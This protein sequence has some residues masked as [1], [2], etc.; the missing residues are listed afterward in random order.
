MSDTIIAAG[1]APEASEL[2]PIVAD[3]LAPVSPSAPDSARHSAEGPI[4][5][6]PD[7]PEKADRIEHI[8]RTLRDPACAR[9]V[10]GDAG[11][12]LLAALQNVALWRDDGS[13]PRSLVVASASPGEGRTTI[14]TAMA[15]LL[16]AVEPQLRVLLVDADPFSDAMARRLYSE[17]RGEGL[18]DYLDDGAPAVG[19]LPRRYMFDNLHVVCAKAEDDRPSPGRVVASRL[20]AFRAAT[21]AEYDLVIYDGPAH[22]A[23]G[24][25]VTLARVVGAV[26]LVVRYR[27]PLREQI[28]RLISE[29]DLHHVD[30]VG[31]V[32]NRRRLPI[33]GWLYGR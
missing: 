11:R 28:Q 24:E 8:V 33:P 20:A 1:A 32:F 21:E 14:A 29:L 18:F 12:R 13:A 27:R 7:L 31:A 9:L 19:T 30:I 6:A 10:R 22:S 25:L 2:P 4:S 3:A 23:G 15:A 5:A 17:A 26:L 16:A